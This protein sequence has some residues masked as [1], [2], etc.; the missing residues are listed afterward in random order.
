VV[1]KL[2]TEL[3]VRCNSNGKKKK[4]KGKQFTKEETEKLLPSEEKEKL[5]SSAEE[6]EKEKLSLATEDSDLV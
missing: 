4:E 6:G 2:L 5:L 1:D 3:N